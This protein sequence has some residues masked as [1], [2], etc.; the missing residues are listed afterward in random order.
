VAINDRTVSF[1]YKE[2]AHG[3]R[4]RTMTLDGAEFL[5]RFLMHAVPRGFMR[6]R[7][8]GLL[9]NR[10]RATNLSLCRRLIAT[11]L[12]AMHDD[13]PPPLP[14]CPICQRGHLIAGPNLSP[15][16]LNQLVLRLDTS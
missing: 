8:F 13:A 11:P 3:H 7:H 15:S 2:Y 1:A 9:A 10:V 12:V 5:R 6:I 16:Q 4:H 14:L